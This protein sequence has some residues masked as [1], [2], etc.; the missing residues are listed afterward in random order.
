MCPRMGRQNF[1][2]PSSR[3]PR[4]HRLGAEDGGGQDDHLWVLLTKVVGV[5]EVGHAHL[6]GNVVVGGARGGDDL[7]GQVEWQG[8]RACIRRGEAR[9]ERSESGAQ[10]W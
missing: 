9:E 7:A 1:P 2:N 4:P 10:M 5:C 8:V 6:G 3:T